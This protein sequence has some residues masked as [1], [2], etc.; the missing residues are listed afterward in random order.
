MPVFPPR[1][2]KLWDIV[3]DLLEKGVVNKRYSQYA[4]LAFLVPKPYGGL[5]TVVDSRLLNKKAMID[6]FRMPTVEDAF[7]KFYTTKALSTL[8]LNSRG[9]PNTVVC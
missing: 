3:H 6:A 2:Q 7:A 5:R 4:S 9:L 1:L 8:D